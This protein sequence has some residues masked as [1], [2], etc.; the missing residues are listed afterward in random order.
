MFNTMLQLLDVPPV[1][2]ANGNQQHILLGKVLARYN[3]FY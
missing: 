2:G 1:K 3:R